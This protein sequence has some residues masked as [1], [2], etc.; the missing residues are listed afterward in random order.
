MLTFTHWLLTQHNARLCAGTPFPKVSA[1]ILDKSHL[2][3]GEGG[4][5]D[6]RALASFLEHCKHEAKALARLRHPGI[7][8]VISPIEELRSQLV[9]VTEA[10]ECSLGGYLAAGLK[11]A[12]VSRMSELEVKHGLLQLAG[13]V[14]FLHGE[15]GL[16]HRGICPQA[17]FVAA[18]GA[19]LEMWGALWDGVCIWEAAE[20]HGF[21]A[22]ARSFRFVSSSLRYLIDT[23]E[24]ST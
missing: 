8:R 3:H 4:S 19:S 15:A 20:R 2:T 16:V 24:D 17:A 23:F 5:R 7:L 9:F 10:V 12:A 14:A 22:L 11:D 18:S 13:A 6:E 1:W 21:V